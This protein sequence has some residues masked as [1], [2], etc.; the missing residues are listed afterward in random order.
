MMVLEYYVSN[1]LEKLN[2]FEQQIDI[3]LFDTLNTAIMIFLH[4][5][6]F[7]VDSELCKNIVNT[8]S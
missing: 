5:L 1:F 3:K 4:G 2:F 8:I 6:P 7:E